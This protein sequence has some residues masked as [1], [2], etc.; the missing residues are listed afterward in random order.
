MLA[1]PVERITDNRLK[2]LL[3]EVLDALE[4]CDNPETLRAVGQS[5][6]MLGDDA[7]AKALQKGS[8]QW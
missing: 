5:L 1:F 4:D 6:K 8:R 3:R 7:R 2:G